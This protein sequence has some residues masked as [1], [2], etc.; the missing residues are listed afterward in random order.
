MAER[1]RRVARTFAVLLLCLGITLTLRATRT[2]AAPGA[3]PP[4]AQ[5]AAVQSAA[6]DDA[7]SA[8][9][10]YLLPLG[11]AISVTALLG[12]RACSRSAPRGAMRPYRPL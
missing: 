2:S 11:L 6:R 8:F 1:T 10:A 12:L 3:S 9:G 4:T 7:V 5:V